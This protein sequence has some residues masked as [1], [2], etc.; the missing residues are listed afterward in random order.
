MTSYHFRFAVISV[1][2]ITLF[3]STILMAQEE[4]STE[5]PKAG[6][7]VVTRPQ[8]RQPTTKDFFNLE[9]SVKE[10]RREMIDLRMDVEAYHSR[11][12]TPEIYREILKRLTP[13]PM[14][15]E[16]A[17][18]NGTV[19]KG[20]ITS[21]N[22]DQIVLDTALG[23]LT[24]D[25]TMILNI[26]EMVTPQPKLVF[27]GDAKEEIYQNH[28]IYIGKV[29]NE[30]AARADFIRVIFKVFDS[31]SRQIA[32]DS[33]FV[34]GQNM[35][36]LSGVLTDTALE[37]GQEAEYKVVISIPNNRAVEYVIKEIHSDQMN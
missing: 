21:E 3:G 15:H 12:M 13:V 20:N 24:L 5:K 36:Y 35:T 1:L 9:S 18:T 37:P 25:K 2:L 17:L 7:Q 10:L 23:E 14:T 34:E 6:Q 4:Q 33:A 22:I 26:R 30:G 19:V 32:V 11:E 31:T 8:V 27:L 16:V 29:K 28:R